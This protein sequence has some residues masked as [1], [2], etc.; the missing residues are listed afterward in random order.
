[1]SE[2]L[3]RAK[4]V[5]L[6]NDYKRLSEEVLGYHKMHCPVCGWDLFATE[7]DQLRTVVYC[8]DC[9]YKQT[10]GSRAI[11]VIAVLVKRLADKQK[12]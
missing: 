8:M 11:N 5:L 7:D 10:L 2:D 12:A 6:V 1:M 9:G 3:S 4:G